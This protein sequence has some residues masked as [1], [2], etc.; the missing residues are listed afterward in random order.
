MNKLLV[1]ITLYIGCS[2]AAKAQT[3]S[4]LYD[5]LNSRE[6]YSSDILL[7]T[8][9]EKGYSI[10]TP[11]DFK[12]LLTIDTTRGKEA[13]SIIASSKE[14]SIK[15]GDENGI[16]YGSLSVAEDIRNGIPIEKIKSKQESPRLQFRAIKYDLPW[17]TYRHSYALDQHQE[18]C[19]DIKYWESF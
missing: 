4:L 5:T 19:A 17:D 13:F 6:K 8:L 1:T 3:V 7:K 10:K 14:I 11:A 15:G 9:N 12:V 18:T 2:I 16:L